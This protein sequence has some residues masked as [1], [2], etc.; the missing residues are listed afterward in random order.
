MVET[1]NVSPTVDRECAADFAWPLAPAAFSLGVEEVHLWATNLD[2]PAST[3]QKFAS[4]L[5]PPESERAA[6]FRFECHRS[7]YVAGRGWLRTVLSR[8]LATNP[9]QITFTYG[10]HGK[11]ALCGSFT[12]LQFNLAHSENLA[13]LAV[14]LHH[15]IG[16]DVE[17]IKPLADAEQLVARFFS[18]RENAAFQQLPPEQKPNAFFNLWTRKEAWLKATGEGIAHSLKLVEVS[19]LPGEPARL[20]SLPSRGIPNERWTLHSLN[21]ARGFAAALA[22]PAASKHLST[23]HWRELPDTTQDL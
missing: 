20:L 10:P 18:P 23:W 13:L 4:I 16:V 9:A 2:L 3:L 8:Y 17:L 1:Q 15:P 22:F 6:R 21:P 5:S 14:N 12:P 19:F 7:R 11:P